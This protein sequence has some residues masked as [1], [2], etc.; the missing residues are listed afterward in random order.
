MTKEDKLLVILKYKKD[1]Y[2]RLAKSEKNYTYCERYLDKVTLYDNLIKLVT[3][4][5]ELEEAYQNAKNE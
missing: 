3:N 2:F 1:L 5:K 4:E